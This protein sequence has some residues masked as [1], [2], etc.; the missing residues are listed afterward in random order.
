[1]NEIP[2]HRVH[3]PDYAIGKYPVTNAEFARFVE[4]GGYR[5]S[6]LWTTGGWAWREEET[7]THPVDWGKS[8]CDD[9]SQPVMGVCWYEAMA[10]CNWL[11]ARTGKPYRLPS[12]AEWEKAA[13]GTDGRQWPWG[14]RWDPHKCNSRESGHGRPTPVGQYSP[15]GDSPYGVADMAGNVC[16]WTRSL[17]ERYPYDPSDGRENLEAGRDVGRVLRGGDF[18]L[19][20]WGVRCAFRHGENPDAWDWYGG[21]RIVASPVHL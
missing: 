1:V 15:D 5:N 6:Q 20:D 19:E 7:W 10:Y 3:L 21:F 14:N 11:A 8:G 4:D 16:Q 9:P 18:C 17:Y 12:E 13:R 2:Y